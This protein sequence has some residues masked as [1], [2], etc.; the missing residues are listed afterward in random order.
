MKKII[1]Y[2]LPVACILLFAPQ[3]YSQEYN[4]SVK[5]SMSASKKIELTFEP[6]V[7]MY[8]WP[9]ISI[10]KMRLYVEGEYEI[11]SDIDYELGFRFSLRNDTDT[12]LFVYED[13]SRIRLYNSISFEIYDSKIIE[14]SYRFRHQITKDSDEFEYEERNKIKFEHTDYEDVKPYISIESYTTNFFRTFEKAKISL[15]VEHDFLQKF[16]LEE[17]MNISVYVINELP[18]IYYELGICLKLD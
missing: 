6:R 15:G 3:I 16:E 14:L 12:E 9:H 4:F 1:Q 5:K 17:Y 2:I 8:M 11:F 10:S 18:R 7:Y 13:D